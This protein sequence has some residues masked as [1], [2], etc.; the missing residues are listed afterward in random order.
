MKLTDEE[1][2]KF[3]NDMKDYAKLFANDILTGKLPKG[4][5]LDETDII[6]ELNLAFLRIAQTF[7]PKEDGRSLRSYCYEYGEKKALN[8]ILRMYRMIQH[9]LD[10][11]SIDD[12]DEDVHHQYGKY[13]F[14][15]RKELSLVIDEADAIENLRRMADET[16]RR[17]ISLLL[18]G[19]DEREIAHRIGI[20]QP[21]VSKR[22]R[23]LVKRF[24]DWESKPLG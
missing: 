19:Y 7:K 10:T 3:L 5:Y 18:L 21:A 17:I 2:T 1:K 13:D 20:S 15:P 8:E 11:I 9:R 14:E 4:Y 24:N 22:M 12:E 16:D 6:H 23:R